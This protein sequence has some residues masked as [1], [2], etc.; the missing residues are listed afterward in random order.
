VLHDDDWACRARVILATGYGADVT[1]PRS[2][3]Q[4]DKASTNAP[5]LAGIGDRC[6]ESEWR[7]TPD[8]KE[9]ARTSGT[10]I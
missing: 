8:R 2:S 4:S 10:Q 3:R 7:C 5:I 9:D 6:H 1:A